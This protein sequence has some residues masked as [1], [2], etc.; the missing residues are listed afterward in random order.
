MSNINWSNIYTTGLYYDYKH[1]NSSNNITILQP[2]KTF[3]LY[4]S[5]RCSN[6]NKFMS[7]SY[8]RYSYNQLLIKC[9]HCGTEG[10]AE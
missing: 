9:K 4:F 7:Y 1:N 3:T 10:T 6:C 2:V 5:V 8:N